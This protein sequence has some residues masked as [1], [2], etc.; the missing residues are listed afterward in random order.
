MNAV[1]TF[2]GSRRDRDRRPDLHGDALWNLIRFYR[3][4]SRGVHAVPR[5]HLDGRDSE[6]LEWAKDREGD[7]G[8]SARRGEQHLRQ[9]FARSAT[10]RRC[11]C[12]A[13]LGTS[14]RSSEYHVEAQALHGEPPPSGGDGGD[15]V[16][17]VRSHHR[18]PHD[19]SP[20]RHADHG[21]REDGKRTCRS[22]VHAPKLPPLG[23]CRICVVEV[24]TPPEA[25]PGRSGRDRVDAQ[26]RQ[27]APSRTACT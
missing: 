26:V 21:R 1:G 24:G 6:R 9:S 14:V 22:S 18:R 23:A 17:M 7:N 20:G 2:L 10:R 12:R 27:A 19:R 4:E 15:G 3:H 16:S 25:I 8:P 11:R 5:R 13:C